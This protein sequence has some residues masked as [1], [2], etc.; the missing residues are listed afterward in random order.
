MRCTK[1]H[2]VRFTWIAFGV[3]GLVAAFFLLTE[4]RAHLLGWVPYLIFLGCPLMHL[5]MHRSHGQ[6]DRDHGSDAPG[7]H[8]DAR[9]SQPPHSH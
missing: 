7:G 8:T 4:H 2:S 1:Q 6:A 3:F 9:V 5:F